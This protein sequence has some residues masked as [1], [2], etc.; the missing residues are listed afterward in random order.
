MRHSRGMCEQNCTNKRDTFSENVF[1]I[2]F[3][4]HGN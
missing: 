2:R 3:K 4:I 1:K